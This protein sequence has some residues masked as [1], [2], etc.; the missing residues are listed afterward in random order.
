MDNLSKKTETKHQNSS[1]NDPELW[2]VW[3]TYKT[4]SDLNPFLS[5]PVSPL[6]GSVEEGTV[7]PQRR[8]CLPVAS[9]NISIS[10][11]NILRNNIGKDLSKVKMPVQLNEPLNTL[12]RLCEEL[13]YSELLNKAANTH[14]PFQ[15]MV[16]WLLAPM[17]T[18]V[19]VKVAVQGW[20]R[21]EIFFRF[22]P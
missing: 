3:F 9:P 7:L 16:R 15:R 8:T 4:K 17:V 11:W 10:V 14:D 2:S 13:E 19:V 18:R 5:L 20:T 6:P 21:T 1:K 22:F 12:Q